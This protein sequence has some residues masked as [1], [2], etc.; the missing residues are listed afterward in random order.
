MWIESLEIYGFGKLVE[1][2]FRLQPG[3]NLIEGFNEAGKSTMK[4]F[5]Q[6]VLFGFESRRNP[7]LRYEPLN[8]GKFGGAIQMIDQEGQS[9]R[10]E[11][12]YH[13]KISGDVRIYLPNGDIVGE[14]YLPIL[15]HQINEK[16]YRQI[17]SFGLNEIQHLDSLQDQQINSFLY[18][19][20]TGVAKQILQMNQELTKKEQ[21]LFKMGGKNPIINSLFTEM[22]DISNRMNLLKRKHLQHKEILLKIEQLNRNIDE[23]DRKM[24]NIK[25]ELK[26]Y[27]KAAHYYRTYRDLKEIK[28]KLS[29]YS[30]EPIFPENGIERLEMIE[31]KVNEIEV[32]KKQL[33]IKKMDLTKQVTTIQSQLLTE[34]VRRQIEY[35]RDH[36]PYYQQNKSRFFQLQNDLKHRNEEINESRKMLG[37]FYSEEAIRMFEYSIADKQTL[38]TIIHHLDLKEKDLLTLDLKFNELKQRYES[39]KL[40]LLEIDNLSKKDQRTKLMI[41]SWLRY[42]IPL[43]G[44]ISSF[45]FIYYKQWWTAGIFI[46]L[47]FLTTKQYHHLFTHLN[48]LSDQ[49]VVQVKNE[50]SRL[51][52][53]I[54]ELRQTKEKIKEEYRQQK[55]LLQKWL[56]QHRLRPDISPI[57]IF[58]T[59]SFIQKTKELYKAQ[60]LLNEEIQALQQEIQDFEARV[61][62]L[63]ADGLTDPNRIEEKVYQWIQSY[64][65]DQ[66]NRSKL[67]QLNLQINDVI[68]EMKRL[69]DRNHIEQE[70]ISQLFNYARVTSKEE[71]YYRAKDYATYQQLRL[72]YKQYFF[73]IRNG[74]TT[75]EEYQQIIQKLEQF[76]EN[77]M[78]HMIDQRKERQ[79]QLQSQLKNLLEAKGELQNQ[80][81]E[82][83]EDRSLSVLQHEYFVLQSRLH[84]N[85]KNWA[86]ISIAKYLLQQTMKIYETE[87][88]PEVIRKASEYFR[89]MTGN[90]YKR[91]FA[92][93]DEATIKVLRMD[94]RIFEPQYLSRG[95]VEQLFIAMRFALIEEFTK[96]VELPL[97]FDDIF[98]NFDQQRLQHTLK[99]ITELSKNHQVLIFTCHTYLVSKM[100]EMIGNIYTI[101]I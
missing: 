13:H 43:I 16:V 54:V 39:N 57:I 28:W 14:E 83:E 22:D 50:I 9:Y 52:K 30:D 75:D 40:N 98:V 26:E 55:D 84:E 37:H 49:Q 38:Q 101:R 86:T 46:L 32:E 99:A 2:T 27:E 58:D 5:I 72:Q 77:E 85:V 78:I 96:K 70:K 25:Q 92:P 47:S 91:V 23:I 81:K 11:R 74:C 59:I 76:E 90:Q 65:Q 63:H 6:A 62:S 24:D 3:L 42:F 95:T 71:F 64:Q 97:I 36:L 31:S 18:H 44:L 33:E 67:D 53:E 73:S 17:F 68:G 8:G 82:M 45:V 29:K 93:L 7:H 20:G 34:Q 80:L 1:R 69:E 15:L 94:G 89:L 61:I 19:A 35:L 100:K 48:Q 56:Q 4:A 51:E 79:N 10:I 60:D 12:V 21:E 66:E 88:Q 87:K 41:T